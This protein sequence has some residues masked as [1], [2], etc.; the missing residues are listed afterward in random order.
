[1][2]DFCF[3]Q[4]ML[5]RVLDQ[6]NLMDRMMAA[7]DV[8]P[9][10]A[11]RLDRGMAFYEVRSRCIDCADDRKCRAWLAS[12]PDGKAVRP[13]AF[14]RNTD[15]FR[16]AT[17]SLADQEMEY[18]HEPGPAALEATVAARNAQPCG[19]KGA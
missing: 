3:S 2:S 15:F 11:A 7:I 1:M 9:I 16:L 18:R 8:L 19:H 13:P 5:R 17:Q 4:P 10:Q 6:A 14:C 12:L